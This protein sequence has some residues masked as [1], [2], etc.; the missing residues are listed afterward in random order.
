MQNTWLVNKIRYSVQT[1][2]KVERL[3][4]VSIFKFDSGIRYQNR[5]M[6]VFKHLPTPVLGLGRMIGMKGISWKSDK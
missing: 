6:T 4:S 1:Q 3:Y 2:D 5:G